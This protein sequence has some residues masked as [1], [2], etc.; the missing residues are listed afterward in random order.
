MAKGYIVV[1]MPESCSECQLCSYDDMRGHM[2]FVCCGSIDNGFGFVEISEEIMNGNLKPNWCPI[3]EFPEGYDNPNRYE[4]DDAKFAEG[5][6]D[7]LNDI[8]GDENK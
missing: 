1:D 3:K 6:N 8:L 7:C 4:P 2:E 5:Y